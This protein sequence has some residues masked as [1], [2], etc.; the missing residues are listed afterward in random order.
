MTLK[1]PLTPWFEWSKWRFK[2]QYKIWNLY[3]AV[4]QEDINVLVL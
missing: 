4:V 1:F 3:V 2:I